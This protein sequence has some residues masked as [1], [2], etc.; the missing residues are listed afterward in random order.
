MEPVLALDRQ[1]PGSLHSP[2][3]QCPNTCPAP[4]RITLFLARSIAVT[5][6]A[7]GLS[8]TAPSY[9][10]IRLLCCMLLLQPSAT[11]QH[12]QHSQTQT[13]T[14]RCAAT[15]NPSSHL[16]PETRSSTSSN[17]PTLTRRSRFRHDS[18]LP[19]LQNSSARR[20]LPQA[21]SPSTSYAYSYPVHSVRC[22]SQSRLPQCQTSSTI[23][24]LTTGARTDG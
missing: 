4:S 2:L 1:C 11:P 13:P 12:S 19:S 22:S 3:R 5:P 20:L 6:S 9:L 10:F 14:R 24:S 8:Q 16:R 21:K 18:H 23:G 15:R 7:H 17:R